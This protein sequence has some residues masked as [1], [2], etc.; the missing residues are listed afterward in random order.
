[1]SL[2]LFASQLASL[3]VRN[4]EIE[5]VM[6]R[7]PATYPDVLQSIIWMDQAGTYG[8]GNLSGSAPDLACSLGDTSLGGLNGAACV[9]SKLS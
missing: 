6:A 7:G 4:D 5:G 8:F 9:K 1:M 3:F 2:A